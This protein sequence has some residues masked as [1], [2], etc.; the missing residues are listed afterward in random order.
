MDSKADIYPVI[1]LYQP[2]ATWIMRLWKS[3]ETREHARFASLSGKTILIHAGKRTD[4]SHLTKEN[5]YLSKSQIIH[6]PDE[7]INGYIL[8]SAFVQKVGWL[9]ES[10]S[11]LSLIDCKSTRRFGL[12]LE[13]IK[14]FDKP[15]PCQGEMGIW[16]YDLTNKDKV[17]RPDKSGVINQI[18]FW[19]S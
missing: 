9:N 10:H 7:I 17:R 15:I 6:N 18:S 12:F 11:K 2:W 4:G 16:Y 1:T 3:I 5:P 14:P 8:G 19:N 13:D